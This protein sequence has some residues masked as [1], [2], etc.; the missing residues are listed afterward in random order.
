MRITFTNQPN[1]QSKSVYNYSGIVLKS[2]AKKVADNSSDE[3]SAIDKN[4]N[5]NLS[6]RIALITFAGIIGLLMLT[7]GMQKNTNIYL[8]KFKDYIERKLE[9]SSLNGSSKKSAFYEYIIRKTN[10]FIRK[11]ESINN[12]TSI[13]D[14][15]FMKLMYKTKPTKKIH[16][17]ITKYFEN[18]SQKTVQKSYQKTIQQFKLMNNKFDELD[19]LIL[20]NSPDEEIEFNN[21]KYKKKELVQKAKEYREKANWIFDAFTNKET[22][23]HRYKYMNEVTDSLY[24]NFWDASFKGFWSKDNKFKKK[25]MWHT[26]IAAEQIKGDKT[27]LARNIALARNS[28]SYT[29]TEHTNFIHNYVK[30][31]DGIVPPNDKE[32]IELINRLSWFS[33]QAEIFETNKESFLRELEKLEEHNIPASGNV[34]A[35][36]QN[37]FKKSYIKLIKDYINETA[38]GEIQDMMSIYYKIAP[39]ELSKTGAALS[40]KKAVQSFDKS[41]NTEIVEFFDKIRDLKLG[42]APTDVLT[43]VLSFIMLSMG[44]GYAKDKD[45]RLSVM[46]KSGIPIVGAI[47]TAAFSAT[48]LVSGGK[49][50]ALGL[51]SGVI[52]NQ[53][54]IFANNAYKLN[55]NKIQTIDV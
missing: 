47:S 50:L 22:M 15:L 31:L 51:L 13:K 33:K 4:E 23:E 19:E 49:S 54:G 6:S 30:K 26:F 20:K 16:S 10:S 52:L 14:I 44:L 36:T 8:N 40:V 37:K 21:Q 5:S 17:A 3:N 43:I 7:R 38:P 1:Q 25:E 45:E 2:D 27:L 11:S 39:F 53:L 41:V 18:L 46:L 55:A 29:S 32:G 34:I 24:S 28:L 48:K 12:I 42:S 35:D 9:Y